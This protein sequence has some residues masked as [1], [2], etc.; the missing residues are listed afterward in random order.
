MAEH[1]LHRVDVTAV[2]EQMGGKR[3]SQSVAGQPSRSRGRLDTARHGR[4]VQLVLV[5]VP[6]LGSR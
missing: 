4:F 2:F 6:V 5:A 1:F 3:M